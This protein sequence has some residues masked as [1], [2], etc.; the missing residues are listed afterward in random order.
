M[1]IDQLNILALGHHPD[2]ML[3]LNRLLNAPAKWYG[4]TV[5]TA[6]EALAAFNAKHFHIVLLC[7]G[8]TPEEEVALTKTLL[9]KNPAVIVR[10]HFGGGSGLLSNEIQFV[11]EQ[12]NIQLA[13]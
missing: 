12:G 2:I 8:V 9:Q 10:R 1:I 13:S 4:E 6:E 11:L 7:A 3:V 5:N